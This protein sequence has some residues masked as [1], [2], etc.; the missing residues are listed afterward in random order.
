M[1]RNVS[2]AALRRHHWAV[3]IKSPHP[4]THNTHEPAETTTLPHIFLSHTAS[5]HHTYSADE[6][7]IP[8]PSGSCPQG[9]A[10]IS[11]PNIFSNGRHARKKRIFVPFN[12]IV[13]MDFDIK[14]FYSMSQGENQ[15]SS[16]F[17]GGLFTLCWRA[18]YQINLEAHT[19]VFRLT[20]ESSA[21]VSN[22]RF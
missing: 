15:R 4:H 12:K 1:W 10:L 17:F 13:L 21:F 2:A 18:V 5:L 22:N 11:T 8:R 9:R 7:D 20:N 3:R 19:S 14:Y 16:S 6:G